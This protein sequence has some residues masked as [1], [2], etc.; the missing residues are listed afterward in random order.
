VVA[1]AAVG[2]PDDHA[3]EKIRVFV[4]LSNKSIIHTNDIMKVCHSQ[5]AR[6]MWPQEIIITK[7]F[8]MNAHG[9]VIKS[10]FRETEYN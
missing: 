10:K 6:H 5:L 8:P 7:S 3:G 4:I 9:K 1:A 2:V